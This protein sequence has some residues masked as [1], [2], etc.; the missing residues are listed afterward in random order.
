MFI[1]FCCLCP[2]DLDIKLN[3]NIQKG[4][5]LRCLNECRCSLPRLSTFHLV[6]NQI[7]LIVP[8]NRQLTQRVSCTS[9]IFPAFFVSLIFFYVLFFHSFIFYLIYFYLL[10]LLLLLFFVFGLSCLRTPSEAGLPV[11]INAYNHTGQLT[12]LHCAWHILPGRVAGE[13]IAHG[14][15]T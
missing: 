7:S 13:K 3:F 4:A 10:S 2:P 6:S 12:V 9:S 11:L 15:T 8:E 1:H 5:Y 14:V